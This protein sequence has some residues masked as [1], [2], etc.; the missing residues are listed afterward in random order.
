MT[1]TAALEDWLVS[2]WQSPDYRVLTEA[3]R[4]RE[5][6][7][8]PGETAML[9]SLIRRLKPQRVLEIGTFFAQT[10]LAMAEAITAN[11]IGRLDTI[12]PFGGDR[13]PDIMAKW[14]EAE[15]AVTHFQPIYSMTYF[16]ELEMKDETLGL[17]FVDGNHTFDYALYD[18][19]CA[20]GRL[21]PGG[22]IVVDNLELEGPYLATKLFLQLNHAWKIFCHGKLLSA[23]QAQEGI[24]RTRIDG[25]VWAVLLPPSAF[26]ISGRGFTRYAP[27]RRYPVIRGVRLNIVEVPRPMNVVVN[28]VHLARAHYAHVTGEKHINLVRELSQELR[29]GQQT[30][31][32]RFDPPLDLKLTRED[33]HFD[34][35]L[36][37]S[38]P[39]LEDYLL[40]DPAQPYDLLYD[41]A[42]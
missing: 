16:S 15:R 19:S 23:A 36:E 1:E 24:D 41:D 28:F 26:S 37:I 11:G 30:A 3:M 35:H 33:V 6:I 13:V 42:N 25:G 34:Y 38:L 17:A 18:L 27:T 7:T 5:H 2:Y 32:Y 29:P 14:R 31:E 12:D 40:L 10:T 22:V 20:A 39:R 4:Q 9:V 8:P 21:A